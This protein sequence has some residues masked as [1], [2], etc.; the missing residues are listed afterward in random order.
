MMRAGLIKK[1]GLG[2]QLHADGLRAIRK[3]ENIIRDELN[4]AGCVE[5]V[6][7]WRSRRVVEETGRF[8]RWARNAAVQGPS[9]GRD[10]DPAHRPSR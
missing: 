10:C 9:H 4:K 3:V 7:P 8:E 5:L 2:L 1:L 6:M